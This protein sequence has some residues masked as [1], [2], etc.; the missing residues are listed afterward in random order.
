MDQGVL[1]P[2]TGGAELNPEGVW[3]IDAQLHTELFGLLAPGLPGEAGRRAHYFARVTN[4]G[5]AVDVSDFYAQLY[6]RA[7]F[8]DD[9]PAL[10]AA[11][12][13]DFVPDS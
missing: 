11:A 1:P 7:F 6:A 13:A 9:V 2:D 10:I 3:S 5:L 4:S 12:Q 8:E